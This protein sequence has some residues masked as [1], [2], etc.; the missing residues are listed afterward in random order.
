MIDILAGF[1]VLVSVT[2]S[3]WAVWIFLRTTDWNQ[4]RINSLSKQQRWLRWYGLGVC[5][6]SV[7]AVLWLIG[8][9]VMG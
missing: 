7:L 1:A 9:G 3:A 8:W 6:S 4:Q 2:I 5:V